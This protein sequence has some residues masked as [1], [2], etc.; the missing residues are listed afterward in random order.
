[1][2]NYAS[3]ILTSSFRIQACIVYKCDHRIFTRILVYSSTWFIQWFINYPSLNIT[4]LILCPVQQVIVLYCLAKWEQPPQIVFQGFN[5]Q[6][7]N[8][9]DIFT[10]SHP[11]R[12]HTL[13]TLSTLLPYR[14]LTFYIV[15]L[16]H[17]VLSVSRQSNS[18][19]YHSD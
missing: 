3:N 17:S 4:E 12:A 19:I 14:A 15:S 18:D 10:T 7:A 11:W 13:I 2:K 8:S 6:A 5:N 16:A 9:A 1:M